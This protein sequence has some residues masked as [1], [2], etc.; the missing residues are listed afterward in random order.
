MATFPLAICRRGNMFLEVY[1]SC[2]N[3]IIDT[4]NLDTVLNL[5]N[6]YH[7][8]HF[9]SN[10]NTLWF[11]YP[12]TYST[13][14]LYNTFTHT[15]TYPDMLGFD[16]IEEFTPFYPG[17]YVVITNYY[18]QVDALLPGNFHCWTS[19]DTIT[20]PAY[21][22]STIAA[23][24]IATCGGTIYI[25]VDVDSNEGVPPFQYEIL[26][27]PQTFP[28]QDSTIF[29]VYNY[30]TYLV[31]VIDSCGNVD[32]RY[33]TV[34]T[35][36]ITPVIRTGGLCAGTSV[37]LSELASPY[38]YYRWRAPNG[39]VFTG[40]T[41]VINPFTEADTG[42]YE[43]TKVIDINGCMDSV[44][45]TH[46]LQ[47]LDTFSQSI[48]ICPGDTLNVGYNYYTQAGVYYDT[49]TGSLGC[50]SIEITTINFLPAP[51]LTITSDVPLNCHSSQLVTVG[52]SGAIGGYIWS[53][54]SGYTDSVI[55]VVAGYYGTTLEVT[56]TEVSGCTA[57]ATIF[58]APPRQ[59]TTAYYPISARAIPYTTMAVYIHSRGSTLLF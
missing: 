2:G 21:N 24:D 7:I 35:G 48:S 9:C 17:I 15:Y 4:F 28:P 30:G 12:E 25:H 34:D 23:T 33:I 56:A 19:R 36:R 31:G 37:S 55:E 45:G 11:R 29:I 47:F 1:D 22:D 49:I 13:F 46:N 41:L 50:D 52:V 40:N 39:S 14:E 3:S 43:I 26:S 16:S 53:G 51:P 18:G 5:G 38:F 59:D 54:N 44:R 42:I 57:S 27:G 58:I 8:K 6:V 32:A 10:V 20:I